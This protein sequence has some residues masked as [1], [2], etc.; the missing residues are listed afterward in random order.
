M[1]DRWVSLLVAAY[2]SGTIN[3]KEK[4]TN[5]FYYI[6]E[7]FILN[8]LSKNKFGQFLSIL[9]NQYCA[10]A[11]IVPLSSDQE[12][13]KS[14]KK[15]AENTLQTWKKTLIPWLVA[16]TPEEKD[17]LELY[18]ETFGALSSEAVKN[19]VNMSEKFLEELKA[20][21]NLNEGP[22]PIKNKVD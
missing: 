22:K 20:S 21:G 18:E 8:E 14:A 15:A 12:L 13:F 16:E 1:D 2:T 3:L 4:A 9:H 10:F 11:Q 19:M 5:P 17:P 6:K 7:Q